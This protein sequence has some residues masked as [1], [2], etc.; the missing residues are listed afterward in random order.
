MT[1]ID[2]VKKIEQS[3]S[4]NLQSSIFNL[5]FRLAGLGY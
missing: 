1:T 2:L 4:T 5:Q 3:D